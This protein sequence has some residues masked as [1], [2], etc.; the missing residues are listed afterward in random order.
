M[1]LPSMASPTTTIVTAAHL[2]PCTCSKGVV[3]GFVC[4]T[5]EQGKKSSYIHG[6]WSHCRPAV[7]LLP[8]NNGCICERDPRLHLSLQALSACR[9]VCCTRVRGNTRQGSRRT[10]K[11]LD[12]RVSQRDCYAHADALPYCPAQEDG[13]LPLP[14]LHHCAWPRLLYGGRLC[15]PSVL[16]MRYIVRI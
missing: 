13:H 1:T 9:R 11:A 16:H 2:E 14:L 12:Y 10:S 15:A 7:P 3:R 6:T 4:A 8:A 5:T